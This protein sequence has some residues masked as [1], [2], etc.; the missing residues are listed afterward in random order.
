MVGPLRCGHLGRVL[1]VRRK[2]CRPAGGEP[3]VER[4][5]HCEGQLSQE[6]LFFLDLAFARNQYSILE[7]ESPYHKFAGSI[8]GSVTLAMTM[9]PR[10]GDLEPHACK[11]PVKP[12]TPPPR[13]PGDASPPPPVQL[14]VLRLCGAEKEPPSWDEMQRRAFEVA[15][16]L[17]VQP[18]ADAFEHTYNETQSLLAVISALRSEAERDATLL[19]SGRCWGVQQDPPTATSADHA[20]EQT[21][22]ALSLGLARLRQHLRIKIADPEDLNCAQQA[23]HEVADFFEKL[24]AMA[25]EH[26]PARGCSF[27]LFQRMLRE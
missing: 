14:P 19:H 26:A 18:T 6:S 7:N 9:S 8:F 5:R 22:A 21:D 15:M 11:T 23:L 16:V 12:Q 25:G 13:G 24:A 2:R 1:H 3:P 20:A 27:E 4:R 10:Q 17:R